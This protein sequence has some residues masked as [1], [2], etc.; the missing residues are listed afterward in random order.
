MPAIAIYGQREGMFAL[1]LRNTLQQL[2]AHP[3]PFFPEGLSSSAELWGL[4]AITSALLAYHRFAGLCF[5]SA[6]LAL[7]RSSA[8]VPLYGAFMVTAALAL[9]TPPSTKDPADQPSE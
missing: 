7:S 1:A 5:V 8:D 3:D 9:Q 2:S 6:V 4:V